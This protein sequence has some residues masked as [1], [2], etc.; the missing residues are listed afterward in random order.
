[1]ELFLN[2]IN[3]NKNQ[4]DNVFEIYETEDFKEKIGEIHL[5]LFFGNTPID[6]LWLTEKYKND[7]PNEK[8]DKINCYFKDTYNNLYKE[9]HW[10]STKINETTGYFYNDSENLEDKE[11]FKTFIEAPNKLVKTYTKNSVYS[12]II[13]IDKNDEPIIVFSLHFNNDNFES[14]NFSFENY[15]YFI[16]K[17]GDCSLWIKKDNSE[18]KK[19]FKIS[20]EDLNSFIFNHE[21]IQTIEDANN[22]CL[23]F[24]ENTIF[25]LDK[26]STEQRFIDDI[27]GVSHPLKIDHEKLM[28]LKE[29][30]IK[31]LKDRLDLLNAECVV[32]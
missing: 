13:L 1:M 20:E 4:K 5:P 31:F 12:E 28:Q 3:L 30:K 24:V 23:D 14:I 26:R 9:E 15:E 7:F 25:F 18:N 2:Q 21:E 19:H 10:E 27:F 32:E 8:I 6:Y 22:T 16:E 29:E 11:K 17:N